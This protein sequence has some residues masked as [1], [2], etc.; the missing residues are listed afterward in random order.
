MA[1]RSISKKFHFIEIDWVIYFPSKGNENRFL[2][3][4]GVAFLNR[5]TGTTQSGKK[6][7]LE[8]VLAYPE[9]KSNYP[10][11]VRSY[12]ESCGKKSNF[13]PTYLENQKIRDEKEFYDWIKNKTSW[14]LKEHR[15]ISWYQIFWYFVLTTIKNNIR[16]FNECYLR[17]G[18]L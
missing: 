11:T 1:T 2:M 3:K 6:I 15:S 16:Q 17:T 12:F 10:H 8:D 4:Y 18:T 5:K 9:I 13:S 14:I 7:Y